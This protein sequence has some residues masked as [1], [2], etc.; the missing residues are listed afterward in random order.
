MTRY[1]LPTFAIIIPT[2]GREKVLLDTLEQVFAQQLR[3]TEVLLV[4]QTPEHDRTTD[5]TLRDHE[6]S[7]RIRL[8]R[9][10]AP[11]GTA[12]KNA[13]LAETDCEVALFLDDDVL[14]DDLFTLKHIRHFVDPDL[15]VVTGPIYSPTEA[16]NRGPEIGGEV[17]LLKGTLK[18]FTTSREVAIYGGNSSVRRQTAIE[19]GGFDEGFEGPQHYEEND[20]AR[21]LFRSGAVIGR[22]EEAYLIHLKAPTGGCR[23][24][25][26]VWPEWQ[27]SMNILLYTFRNGQGFKEHAWLWKSALRAG[28]LRRE[29]I[30]RPYRQP[31]AWA[32]FL[33]AHREAL[34]RRREIKSRFFRSRVSSDCLEPFP[35]C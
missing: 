32:A 6:R 29:N 30:I 15:D 23:I 20:F 7:G 24:T 26:P 18:R 4:D 1:T 21:R 34:H 17:G 12:A 13:A 19:I 9:R 27:K 10:I 25:N 3:P 11:S 35:R 8:I 33:H 5:D 28:P 16:P 22:D 2:L 31:Q 14:L